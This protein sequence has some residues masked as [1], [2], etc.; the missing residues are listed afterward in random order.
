L[1]FKGYGDR[2]PIVENNTIENRA[3]NRRTE[4]KII[5]T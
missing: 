4:F 5:E 1:T 3:K 2:R